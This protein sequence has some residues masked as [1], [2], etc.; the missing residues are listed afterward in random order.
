M[1]SHWHDAHCSHFTHSARYRIMFPIFASANTA[2][3]LGATPGG[4][5]GPRPTA[6]VLGG[7]T[8][9]TRGTRA[10]PVV[11]GRSTCST[12]P[13]P[14]FGSGG[15]GPTP[16]VHGGTTIST[17]RP[18]PTVVVFGGT[19]GGTGGPGTLGRSIGPE[20]GLSS[21]RTERRNMKRRKRKR[22]RPSCHGSLCSSVSARSL[23][24]WT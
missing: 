16:V 22:K 14:G 12:T 13:A 17:G 21:N 4:T 19:T 3:R 10:T 18:G 7:A 15:P 5:G 9:G 20:P 24:A 23:M 1:P 8:G 6:V 2:V 11:L